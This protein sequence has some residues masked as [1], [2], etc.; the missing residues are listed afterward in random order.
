MRF[1]WLHIVS[2]SGQTPV[3]AKLTSQPLPLGCAH[4]FITSAAP[5]RNAL[6]TT[7]GLSQS[8]VSL[9]RAVAPAAT[10]SLF[11]FSLEHNLLGGKFVYIVLIALVLLALSVSS[12]LPNVMTRASEERGD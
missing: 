2:R 1:L 10:A 9:T 6:G 5:T 12:R 3:C 8:L 7:I 11:A 4:I